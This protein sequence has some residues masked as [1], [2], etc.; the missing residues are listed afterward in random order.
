M[1]RK[2]NENSVSELIEIFMNQ[3]GLGKKYGEFKLLQSWSQMMGP[4]IANKTIDLKIVNDILIVQ[5]SSAPLKNELS[6][7]KT[8]IVERL[9]EAA[10][11]TIIQDIVF[12]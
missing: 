2:S 8:K 12:Q 6:F 9:N 10:G 5:L 7:A 4:M 11:K 1:K 3:Y